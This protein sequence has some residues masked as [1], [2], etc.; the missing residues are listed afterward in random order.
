MDDVSTLHQPVAHA[1]RLQIPIGHVQSLEKRACWN[2]FRRLRAPDG[3]HAWN[4]FDRFHFRVLSR[5]LRY[6]YSNVAQNT[7]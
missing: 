6:C 7:L 4:C 1:V 2:G 5:C 3:M